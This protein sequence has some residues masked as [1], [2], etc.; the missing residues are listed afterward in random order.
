MTPDSVDA[1]SVLLDLLAPI[2][3]ISSKKMFGGHGIFKDGK[4]FGMVD[5]SGRYFLKAGDANRAMFEAA[6]ADKHGRMPYF[7][8]PQEVL[9]DH[10]QL[11]E[12]ARSA[13]ATTR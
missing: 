2:G 5:S 3:G 8:I 7:A 11:L 4:M 12:W 6:G 1:A 9:E 10:A 13:I